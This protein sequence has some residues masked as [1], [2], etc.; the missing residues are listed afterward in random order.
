MKNNNGWKE[1]LRRMKLENI[2]AKAPGFFE[3]SGG[4]EMKI[5]RYDDR[6]ANGLTKCI[7][8]WIN[9]S[10]G[11]ANR[12]SVMG[13]VRKEKIPLAFGNVR[14]IIRYTPATTRKGTADIHAIIQGRHLSI[15]VKIGRDRLSEHQLAEQS[16]VT[17]A[18]GKYFVATDMESF[19]SFYKQN[20]THVTQISSTA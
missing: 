6:T 3:L 8:D 9:F 5:K 15:E 12:I 1:E 20:F 19:V 2:R 4:F 17:E 11:H 14:E 7:I 10:G 13:T 16:R 18:G